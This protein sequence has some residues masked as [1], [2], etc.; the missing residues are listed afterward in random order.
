MNIKDI[1][2][3]IATLMQMAK[4]S[5]C[6]EDRTRYLKEVETL[7]Q[8]MDEVTFQCKQIIELSVFDEDAVEKI[9]NYIQTR[10]CVCAIEIWPEALNK[11]GKPQKWQSVEIGDIIISTGEWKKMSTPYK[12]VKYG[13]QRGFQR[14]TNTTIEKNKSEEF[15]QIS[16]EELKNV[17]FL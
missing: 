15:M 2:F 7:L 13:S 8:K 3:K 12:T 5:N 16:D 6:E 1:K 11:T 10:N 17:P 9:K 14:T 4:V